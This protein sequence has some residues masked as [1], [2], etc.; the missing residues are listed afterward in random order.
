MDVWR[1]EIRVV[2]SADTDEPDGGT[3]LRVVTPN[4]HPA[5]RAAGD[6][7]APAARRGRHDQFGFTGDVHDTIGFIKRVER[8]R[9]PGLAL[10]PAAMTGM[11]DQGF[12]DQTISDLSARAS[13]FH[14]QLHRMNARRFI[15]P[16]SQ[17][18]GIVPAHGMAWEDGVRGDQA[19]RPRWVN[20]VVSFSLRVR[21]CPKATAARALQNCRQRRVVDR[22]CQRAHQAEHSGGLRGLMDCHSSRRILARL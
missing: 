18:G 13:A 10:A 5:G 9:G 19:R 2:Q 16:P 11:N 3:G 4:R 1:T 20:R 12:S 7:L 15:L 6:V 17:R 22:H 8:M 14:V 21:S